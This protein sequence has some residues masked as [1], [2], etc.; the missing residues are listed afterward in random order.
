MADR[1]LRV[2]IVGGGI[3]GLAAANALVRRDIDVTVYERAPRL[4]EIG[5]GV[6]VHP[7]G[8]RQLRQL[9]LGEA[10]RS[11]GAVVGE[12]SAYFRQDG[13]RVAPVQTTDSSGT[14]RGCGMHRADLLGLLAGALPSEAIRTNKECTGFRQDAEAATVEFTD[15][16]SA[17]ADV[18]VAADGIQSVLQRSVTTP[19]TPVHSGSIAFR[20]L[21]PA[22][23]LPWWPT[24]VLHLWMGEGKHFMV[25]PVR[26]GTLLNYVAFIPSDERASESWSAPGDPDA[27]RA[28]FAGW[29]SRVERLLAEVDRCYWWGLYDREPLDRWTDRRLT[30]LGDAA[31]PMLPHLGQGANQAIEDGVALAVLL[32]AGRDDPLGALQEY[33]RL[34]RPRTS[35]VQDAAR[36]NGRRYDSAYADLRQRD[37]EIVSSVDLRLWLSDYDV[38]DEAERAAGLEAAKVSGAL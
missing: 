17:T 28:A 37:A 34:R 5:A 31:H 32:D 21:I 1:K 29:D 36:A 19:G 15:G 26:G 13:T 16:T 24:E 3:G 14:T 33:E 35:Q 18:V 2:A 4:G 38:R 9:G 10:V 23:E 30:L 11:A 6:F 20:G 7:N 12:G 27:L 8:V 25:Y 22:T